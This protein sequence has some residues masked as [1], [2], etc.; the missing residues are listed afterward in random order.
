MIYHVVDLGRDYHGKIYDFAD[1]RNSFLDH[2]P[3]NEYVLYKDSDVEITKMLERHLQWLQPKFPWYDIRQINYA[4]GRFMQLGNPFFTGVLASNKVRWRSKNGVKE[5]LYP[6]NPHGVIDLPLIHN[7]I[8][9]TTH[10]ETNPPRPLLAAR[11]CYEIL[12]YGF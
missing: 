6:R 1:A 5:R 7:H 12:R 9:P 11:K 8:G 4:N 10:W 3:D 2:L